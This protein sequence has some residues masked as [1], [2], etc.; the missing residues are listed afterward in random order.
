MN[1]N[2]TQENEMEKWDSVYKEEQTAE[3][4]RYEQGTETYGD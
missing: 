1:E 4:E 2:T 3:Q